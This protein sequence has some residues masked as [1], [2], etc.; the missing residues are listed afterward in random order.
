MK[1]FDQKCSRC[2][3]YVLLF[4][5]EN[6]VVGNL[7]WSYSGNILLSSRLPFDSGLGF[8]NHVFTLFRLFSDFFPAFF[9]FY[10]DVRNVWFFILNLMFFSSCTC[11]SVFFL[12]SH[13]VSHM[14]FLLK[15]SGGVS[16]FSFVGFIEAKR[17]GGSR[18]SAGFCAWFRMGSPWSYY[19]VVTCSVLLIV[20]VAGIVPV[21]LA[22]AYHTGTIGEPFLYMYQVLY[23]VDFRSDGADPRLHPAQR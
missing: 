16:C 12:I 7:S 1:H 20:P 5:F 21:L 4:P 18:I 13:A 6:A 15:W 3:I 22:G 9:Y 10:L 17:Q 19:T 11:T 23:I 8:G 2:D 14:Y